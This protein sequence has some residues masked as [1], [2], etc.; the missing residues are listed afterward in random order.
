[1]SDKP[2]PFQILDSINNGKSNL[3]ESKEITG[4]DY[5][6]A[7]FIVNKGLSL[8]S[9]T[10]FFA[11]MMNSYPNLSPKAQYEFYYNII[12]KKKRYPKWH[13]VPKIDDENYRLVSTY[14]KYNSVRTKEALSILTQEQIDEIKIKLGLNEIKL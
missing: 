3:I 9:D 5:K 10:L 12:S 13:K 6:G 2:I 11:N 7:M 1:M 14:Y 8:S 4:E